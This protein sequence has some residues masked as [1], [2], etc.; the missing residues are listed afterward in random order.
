MISGVVTFAI[1]S[2]GGSWPRTSPRTQAGFPE[3]AGDHRR[4]EGGTARRSGRPGVV[5]PDGAVAKRLH[6]LSQR[7]L[8]ASPDSFSRP[9]STRTSRMSAMPGDALR[10]SLLDDLPGHGGRHSGRRPLVRPLRAAA[11][12]PWGG[13]GSAGLDHA[14]RR[15]GTIAPAIRDNVLSAVVFALAAGLFFTAASAF[16]STLIDITRRGTGVLGGLMNG[17]VRSAAGSARFV[18]LAAIADRLGKGPANERPDGH[19]LRTHLAVDRFL[20][21]DR[22]RPTGPGHL[23]TIA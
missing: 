10:L 20:A 16:W 3:G 2:S 6:A 17:P 1:A 12:S 4:R 21:P 11:G 13:D 7:V 14:G 8:S 23:N 15:A 22:S 18:C 5:R 9:G 19:R